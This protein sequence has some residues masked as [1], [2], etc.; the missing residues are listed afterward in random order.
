MTYQLT[1]LYR[2][3]EDVEA[4]DRH[5][6]GTH[7]LLAAKLPGLRSY[8]VSRPGP[9][10][11][12]KQPPY[13]LIAVL[14]W[15]SFEA[16]QALLK[17]HGVRLVVGVGGQRVP[18]PFEVPR[19]P[20]RSLVIDGNELAA[21]VHGRGLLLRWPLA[22]ARTVRG[23]GGRERGHDAGAQGHCERGEPECRGAAV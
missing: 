20:V 15:D 11:D 18:D 17:D 9:G 1:A 4:F 16:F 8:S 12:G 19:D 23:G 13:H 6:D 2:H 14:T 10:A 22:T 5:Y 21:D 7:V 3:P